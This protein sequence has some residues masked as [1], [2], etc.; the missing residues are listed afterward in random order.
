MH[1]APRA[2]RSSMGVFIFFH[3]E[4]NEPI[5]PR[6]DRLQTP[7]S[8]FF[9]RVVDTAGARANSPRFQRDSDPPAASLRRTGR[10]RVFFA[11]RRDARRGTKGIGIKT[12]FMVSI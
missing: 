1:S 12:Q 9:L 6:R 4:E 3:V 10:R 8:R 7:V 5:T 11:R 2:Y